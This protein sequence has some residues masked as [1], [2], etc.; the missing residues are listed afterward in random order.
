MTFIISNIDVKEVDPNAVAETT[1][2]VKSISLNTTSTKDK[3]IAKRGNES[4]ILPAAVFLSLPHKLAICGQR[5]ISGIFSSGATA[6]ESGVPSK[7]KVLQDWE[8][9]ID[10]FSAF[11]FSS[12][13]SMV[14]CMDEQ[15][16]MQHK[17]LHALI[18][19][20]T[21]LHPDNACNFTNHCLLAEL[22]KKNKLISE[23][24]RDSEE[25][26][27]SQLRSLRIHLILLAKDILVLFPTA[28]PD[29]IL[30]LVD[31]I[32]PAKTRASFNEDAHLFLFAPKTYP[33]ADECLFVLV[34]SQIVAS[35]TRM[36]QD[37]TLHSGGT[38]VSSVA[39]KLSADNFLLS[40][41]TESLTF[42]STVLSRMINYGGNS[43]KSEVRSYICDVCD[44]CL[45]VDIPRKAGSTGLIGRDKR[46]AD[47]MNV[48]TRSNIFH[49]LLN[50]GM[51][52]LFP[53]GDSDNHESSP[54]DALGDIRLL[55]VEV[56]ILHSISSAMLQSSQ[57]AGIAYDM[58]HKRKISLSQIYAL[59]G[60]SS[61][62]LDYMCGFGL[63]FL[64]GLTNAVAIQHYVDQKGQLA[65]E[66]VVLDCYRNI[67]LCISNIDKESDN[68]WKLNFIVTGLQNSLELLLS[69]LQGLRV[70]QSMISKCRAVDEACLIEWKELSTGLFELL[71]SS[72]KAVQRNSPKSTTS[73]TEAANRYYKDGETDGKEIA[74]PPALVS[75]TGLAIAVEGGEDD[76]EAKAYQKSTPAPKA[77]L[78][79]NQV[80]VLRVQLKKLRSVLNDEP[81][82]SD[83]VD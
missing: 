60:S 51:S 64:L 47:L 55:P 34:L 40:L 77:I 62:S 76:E 1:T 63:S 80:D 4:N 57:V 9:L 30:P 41:L 59:F 73:R 71:N 6:I 50:E 10:Q 45:S 38:K 28:I 24:T 42:L 22:H 8:P 18:S 7:S 70:F 2:G 65:T 5:R 15:T 68:T 14:L 21:D 72:G 11:V 75:S 74:T 53:T 54:S 83:K 48:W 13:P 52:I 20:A 12:I 36:I 56:R 44:M 23:Q 31:F 16:F 17:F 27:V 33:D 49:V 61:G 19:L 58:L 67:V 69:D 26:E 46:R 39:D 37:R 43:D 81:S 25:M 35:Q 78:T 3:D 32:I 66:T 79:N 82:G 29:Y